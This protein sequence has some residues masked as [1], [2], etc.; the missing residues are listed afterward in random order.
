MPGRRISSAGG[1]PETTRSTS[2]GLIPISMPR[3]SCPF[4]GRS[5]SS[6]SGSAC[7]GWRTCRPRVRRSSS[8]ITR[9]YC[10][11][12]RS[13]SR[14]GCSTSIRATVT[15]ACSAPTWFTRFLAC[16]AWPGRAGT[17][18]PALTRPSDCSPRASSSA[19]FLRAS[20]GSGSPTASA[21]GCSASGGAGSPRPQCRHACRSS[22]ARSSAP[23]RSIQ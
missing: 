16:P 11:S 13:C 15:C 5:T 12:T 18:G 8:P 2:Q 3:W 7:A 20:R 23:R 10:R 14:R 21:I 4:S 19:C 6:G 1:R 22:P 9:E 17:S